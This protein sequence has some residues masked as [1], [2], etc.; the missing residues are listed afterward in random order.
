MKCFV[1][2]VPPHCSIS[3]ATSVSHAHVGGQ[4]GRHS[5]YKSLLRKHAVLAGH[6][7]NPTLLHFAKG[8]KMTGAGT[9]VPG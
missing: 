1:K 7:A 6:T 5:E 2:D 3:R 4:D 9:A 8:A